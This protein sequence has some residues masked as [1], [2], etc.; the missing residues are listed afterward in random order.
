MLYLKKIFFGRVVEKKEIRVRK[1][2]SILVMI[3]TCV[4]YVPA[5]YTV[6]ATF[7]A[8]TQITAGAFTISAPGFYVLT[9]DL[10]FSPGAS[11]TAIT[12]SSNNVTLDMNGKYLIGG[13]SNANIGI[14]IP[15]S[16]N[17]II[18]RNGYITDF[19][20]YGVRVDEGTTYTAITL[21][22]LT[23][24][25]RQ[26][27]LCMSFS[28][29]TDCFV[30]NCQCSGGSQAGVFATCARF[31]LTD[32]TFSN[33]SSTGLSLTTCQ[34]FKITNCQANDTVAN[35]GI[36]A[37]ISSCDNIVFQ[38]CFFNDNVS[39]GNTIAL[40]AQALSSNYISFFNCEF[41]K[42][43]NVITNATNDAAGLD[44]NGSIGVIVRNSLFNNNN[45]TSGTAS[46][47]RLSGASHGNYLE[48]CIASDNFTTGTGAV[49]G[50]DLRSTSSNSYFNSCIALRN[51][52]NTGASTG[53]SAGTSQINV[54][55]NCQA[56]SNTGGG[57]NQGFL[58]TNGTA[59]NWYA[60]NLAFGHGSDAGNYSSIIGYV[61][62]GVNAIPPAG[63]YDERGIDNI[64]IS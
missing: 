2:V 32:S 45:T 28:E 12:I 16:Q 61:H 9:D 58:D 63:S 24:K 17:D 60:G 41:C 7:I 10:T 54:F 3:T 55:K 19:A 57:A 31:Q 11:S 20:G 42:N 8:P 13:N 52:S 1:I 44:I 37:L 49:N 51:R 56:Y 33:N 59:Q 23:I 5:V 53:F 36:G 4:V 47:V 15:A 50:F 29:A 22:N 39:T 6:T 30:R 18:I 38:N 48:S 35:G 21:E 43:R 27:G 62:L 64:S 40:G 14:E 34:D 46:G 25:D 26:A